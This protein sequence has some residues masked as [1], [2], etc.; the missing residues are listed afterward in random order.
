MPT[1]TTV[2]RHLVRNG[3]LTSGLGTSASASGAPRPLRLEKLFS[4]PLRTATIPGL[5]NKRFRSSLASLGRS[6]L[7][8]YASSAR[9]LAAEPARSPPSMLNS[10]PVMYV[11]SSD[12]SNTTNAATSSGMPNLR[13]GVSLTS[14]AILASRSGPLP[15]IGSHIGV[16]IAAGCMELQRICR[17]CSAQ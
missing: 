5:S 3:A 7:I 16:S 13:S 9:G 17:P 12:A 14:S 11:V 15:S 2:G 6:N 4:I 1:P 8:R 10:V